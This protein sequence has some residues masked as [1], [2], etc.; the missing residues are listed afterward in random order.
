M[1]P[2]AAA[3]GQHGCTNAERATEPRIAGSRRG[4]QRHGPFGAV[5]ERARK[6]EACVTFEIVTVR[7]V[8]ML[9]GEIILPITP[10]VFVAAKSSGLRWS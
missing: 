2:S 7:P 9:C 1:R 6:H 8:Q 5:G 4:A 10:D 3:G